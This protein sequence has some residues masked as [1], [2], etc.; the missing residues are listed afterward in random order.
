MVYRVGIAFW[1]IY[2]SRGMI[3]SVRHSGVVNVAEVEL[4]ILD[5]L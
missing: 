4:V 1:F 5:N 3:W 2:V